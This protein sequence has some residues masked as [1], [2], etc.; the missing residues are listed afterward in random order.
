MLPTRDEVFMSIVIICGSAA[1]VGLYSEC[2][3]VFAFPSRTNVAS[4]PAWEPSTVT[5]HP[6]REMAA[7]VRACV[8]GASLM[9]AKLTP[10]NVVTPSLEGLPAAAG[11][12]AAAPAFAAKGEIGLAREREEKNRRENR[13]TMMR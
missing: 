1:R 12:A 3:N 8:V 6:V 5:V 2:Q 4:F 11:A 10:S 9:A 7:A 13:G